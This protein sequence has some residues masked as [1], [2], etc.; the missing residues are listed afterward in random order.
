M[1]F[2]CYSTEMVNMSFTD[3]SRGR[4]AEDVSVNGT[5]VDKFEL[6]VKMMF[7]YGVESTAGAIVMAMERELLP[8]EVSTDDDAGGMWRNG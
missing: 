2:C 7:N 4:H 1:K 8:A 6:A 5:T 3:V